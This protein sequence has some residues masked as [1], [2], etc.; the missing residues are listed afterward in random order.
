MEVDLDSESDL[1]VTEVRHVLPAIPKTHTAEAGAGTGGVTEGDSPASLASSG[2]ADTGAE[3]APTAAA[4]AAA[5]AATAATPAAAAA[6]AEAAAAAATTATTETPAA[7]AAA[8]GA[9]AI[10]ATVMTEA[11]AAPAAR[12]FLHSRGEKC[13]D[14]GG[15]A[16]YPHS[17]AGAHGPSRG[18]TE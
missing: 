16:R 12:K 8:A 2:K 17:K 15:T 1:D 10:P 13:T 18:N 14:R 6:A 7:A 9:A 5:T 4:A 3:A 11:A